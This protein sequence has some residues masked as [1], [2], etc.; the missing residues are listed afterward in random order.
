MFLMWSFAVVQS[1]F[2]ASPKACSSSMMVGIFKANSMHATCSDFGFWILTVPLISNDPG[3]DFG[4]V[5]GPTLSLTSPLAKPGKK[6]YLVAAG[7]VK[8]NVGPIT[9]SNDPGMD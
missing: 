6:S 8:L 1:A 2:A 5:I 4:K 7:D 9:F 3:M